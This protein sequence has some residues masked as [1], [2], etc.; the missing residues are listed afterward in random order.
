MT[1][2]FGLPN[3]YLT[4]PVLIAQVIE[5]H[6]NGLDF[7]DAFHLANSQNCSQFYTFDEKFIKRA[8]GIPQCDVKSPFD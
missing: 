1:N 8:K 2:L 5:W 3:V 6:K 4:N 7:A